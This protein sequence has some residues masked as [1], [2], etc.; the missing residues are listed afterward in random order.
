MLIIFYY[1][2]SV[3]NMDFKIEN[4]FITKRNKQCDSIE[5]YV[6]SESDRLKDGY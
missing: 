1:V 2:Y 3:P 5:N 4:I 6:L